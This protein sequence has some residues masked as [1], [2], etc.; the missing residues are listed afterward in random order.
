MVRS[1]VG[2]LMAVGQGSL[3]ADDLREILHARTRVARFSTAPA[4]GLALMEVGYPADDEL[5]AQAQ[6]ARRFRG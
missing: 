3:T 1:V 2:A 5:A 6:R 4:H